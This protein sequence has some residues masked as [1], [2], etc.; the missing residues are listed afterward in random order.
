M[1]EMKRQPS[2]AAA[3]AD[4]FWTCAFAAAR[5]ADLFAARGLAL[6]R[7]T[8]NPPGGRPLQPIPPAISPSPGHE[9]RPAPTQPSVQRAASPPIFASYRSEG[10]HA[11]AQV[12]VLPR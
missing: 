6:W 1:L 10:G 9:S 8:L 7:R 11:T 2:P 4:M 12:V 3:A 5:V